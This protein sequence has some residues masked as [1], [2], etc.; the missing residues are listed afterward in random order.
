M[1]KVGDKTYRNIQEQVGKNQEDIDLLK[2]TVNDIDK[3][4]FHR[5][6]INFK[7]V[8]NVTYTARMYIISKD[9]EEYT[10]EDFK[11]LAYNS[12]VKIVLPTFIGD[13]LKTTIY[14]FR[15]VDAGDN[16]YNA[17]YMQLSNGALTNIET[18]IAET[19]I[20]SFIDYII[21]F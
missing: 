13:I 7:I 10:L 14:D 1:I 12:I 17:T 4:Y 20:T 8:Q 11:K 18:Q 9:S 5:V 2:E 21:K 16:L 3:L 15:Y 19:A 6:S